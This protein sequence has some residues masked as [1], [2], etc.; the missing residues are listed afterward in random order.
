MSSRRSTVP[1][2][3]TRT[4]SARTVEASATASTTVPSR[5]TGAPTS[6][7]AFAA[8][9]RLSSSSFPSSRTNDFFSLPAGHMAR[10]CTQRRGG[11]PGF[12][13]PPPGAPG[14]PGGVAQQFDSEYASLMAELGE[15]SAAPPM[16]GGF[17]GAPGTPG[18][19]Q[20]APP[21]PPGGMMGSPGP[22]PVDENGNKIPPWRIA[23]NWCV[24]PFLSPP[25]Q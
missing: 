10:D 14:A 25:R 13:V 15:T 24:S 23:A 22:Q 16:S 12:G 5:R 1:S 9:V 8:E 19:P 18:P 11:N 20:G 2:A 4:R 21:G 3:T 17:A 6:S 7:V